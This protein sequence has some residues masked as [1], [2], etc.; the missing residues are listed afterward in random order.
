MGRRYVSSRGLERD[1]KHEGMR[2]VENSRDRRQARAHQPA[3]R[4]VADADRSKP[5][6]RRRNAHPQKPVVRR[7]YKP[8][9]Q[10]SMPTSRSRR[11]GANNL[12]NLVE[13]DKG[14]N[15][16]DRRKMNHLPERKDRR[17]KPPT[18][19]PSPASNTRRYND[20]AELRNRNQFSH[21]RRR[22]DDKAE[23]RNRHQRDQQRANANP[24][25]RSRTNARSNEQDSFEDEDDSVVSFKKFQRES[26]KSK[27][28]TPGE[29]I[30]ELKRKKDEKAMPTAASNATNQPRVEMPTAARKA[31]LKVLDMYEKVGRQNES[32][33]EKQ[34]EKRNNDYDEEREKKLDAIPLTDFGKFLSK[35]ER[36]E[37]KEYVEAKKKED[38]ARKSMTESDEF[39]FDYPN[40]VREASEEQ[41]TELP[42]TTK[43]ISISE[44]KTQPRPPKRGKN[45]T[46]PKVEEMPVKKISRAL[47]K[48]GKKGTPPKAEEE[49]MKKTQ[50]RP[51]KRGKKVAQV[52]NIEPDVIEKISAKKTQ[53]RP[54]KRGKK[55]IQIKNLK[56]DVIEKVPVKKTQPRPPKRGKKDNQL[57]TVETTSSKKT[58][59][60]PNEL[61]TAG[62]KSDSLGLLLNTKN[63]TLNL[64]PKVP[65]EVQKKR[66]Q[67]RPPKRGKKT[68][69]KVEAVDS[70]S[71][72]P[73]VETARRMTEDNM[74][75]DIN[76]NVPIGEKLVMPV[77]ILH[78]TRKE[79]TQ[80]HPY[81]R[82]NPRKSIEQKDTVLGTDNFL[83]MH[84]LEPYLHIMAKSFTTEEIHTSSTSLESS[85]DISSCAVLSSRDRRIC[86]SEHENKLKLLESGTEKVHQNFRG[87]SIHTISDTASHVK[88]GALITSNLLSESVSSGATQSQL[89]LVSVILGKI[90]KKIHLSE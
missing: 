90:L 68:D 5:T 15:L 49:P 2:A 67:P 46:Q 86:Y 55:A 61:H 88:F 39:I 53:P 47:P 12:K 76:V 33:K 35:R 82:K 20:K 36:D 57:K 84:N 24:N 72:K 58:Q 85:M 11:E 26:A 32:K 25:R 60:R 64:L 51:P 7:Q 83:A 54:P 87:N 30:A 22:H 1:Q 21:D 74:V 31:K 27:G 59:P 44:K 56:P 50:P 16:K 4:R 79:S 66:T 42:E 10:R 41:A 69:K 73:E 52:N 23:L 75:Q 80:P 43:P 37:Y 70:K 6:S 77:D 78:E 3:P 89:P 62:A 38:E 17:Y 18:K 13:Q 14:K 65:S 63:E 29:I 19:S 48:K 9:P 45:A 40:N 8:S 81:Q 34:K 28:K 71:I